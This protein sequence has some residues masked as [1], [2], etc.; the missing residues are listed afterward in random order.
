MYIAWTTCMQIAG[1]IIYVVGMGKFKV[2][3]GCHE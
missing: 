2:F 1:S 3:L